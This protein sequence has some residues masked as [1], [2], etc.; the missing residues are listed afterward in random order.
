MGRVNT[1]STEEVVRLYREGKSLRDV[2]TMVGASAEGV[3]SRLAAAGQP[4]RDRGDAH[5]RFDWNEATLGILKERF[6]AGDSFTQI[7]DALTQATGVAVTRNAAIGKVHRLHWTRSCDANAGAGSTVI[8]PV[9]GPGAAAAFARGFK[10]PKLKLV[11]AGK[12]A[13]LVVPAAAAPKL[14]PPREI[15]VSVAAEPKPWIERK[16]GECAWPVDGAGADTRSCCNP[17]A[18]KTYCTTHE[19]IRPGA[20]PKSWAG[21]SKP[22]FAKAV[23]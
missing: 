10:R 7:A 11:I 21:F 17:T 2:A 5:V 23:A 16:F 19:A 6:E 15:D 3:R 4:T 14:P 8:K 22:A 12:G 20:M 9:R 13:V 1:F 18:G